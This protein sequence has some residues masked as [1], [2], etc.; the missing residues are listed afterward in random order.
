MQ[1]LLCYYALPLLIPLASSGICVSCAPYTWSQCL[2]ICWWYTL[3]YPHEMQYIPEIFMPSFVFYRSTHTDIFLHRYA[4]YLNA[5]FSKKPTDFVGDSLL[6]WYHHYNCS[7]AGFS[8]C[9]AENAWHH[10]CCIHYAWRS[11]S[12][13]WYLCLDYHHHIWSWPI[14]WVCLVQLTSVTVGVYTLHEDRNLYVWVFSIQYVPANHFL[15]CLPW[16][17]R[18]I[19]PCFAPLP[20]WTRCWGGW[21]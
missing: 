9:E 20:W 18:K 21:C 17:L 14:A 15:F 10:G 7:S 19:V 11:T 8:F 16:H 2:C 5:A 6:I 1:Y 12:G 3:P 4:N 13:R